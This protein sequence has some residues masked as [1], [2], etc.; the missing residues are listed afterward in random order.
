M[1]AKKQSKTKKPT[2]DIS[3]ETPITQQ[4]EELR[5]RLTELAASLS[6]YMMSYHPQSVVAGVKELQDRLEY[7]IYEY[8]LQLLQEK[9]NIYEK[10]LNLLKH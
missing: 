9:I 5:N 10:C 8:E 1:T 4:V 7:R 6:I 3:S 2:V